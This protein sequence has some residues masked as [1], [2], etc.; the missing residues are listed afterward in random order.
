VII[1]IPTFDPSQ[2]EEGIRGP[3]SDP[4]GTNEGEAQIDPGE[5]EDDIITE[6]RQ[7]ETSESALSRERDSTERDQLTEEEARVLAEFFALVG[8]GAGI[9]AGIIL[10]PEVTLPILVTA[11]GAAAR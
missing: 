1:D 4:A 2:V 7:T 6:V 8:V 10:A 5:F 3:I 9:A 11:G